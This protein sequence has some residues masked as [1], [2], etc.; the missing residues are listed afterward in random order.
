VR[1]P[2]RAHPEH[3]QHRFLSRR[4]PKGGR[5]DHTGFVVRGE[6][7]FILAKYGTNMYLYWLNTGRICIYIGYIRDEYVLGWVDFYF[8]FEN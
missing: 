4:E 8:F 6:C 7:V 1:R 3:R 2:A 5:G